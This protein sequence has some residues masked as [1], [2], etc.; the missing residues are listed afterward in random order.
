[1]QACF[2]T[3]DE[4]RPGAVAIM[5][6]ARAFEQLASRCICMDGASDPLDPLAVIDIFHVSDMH[7]HGQAC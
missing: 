1:M 2:E 7:G 4:G 5:T 6:L 3:V